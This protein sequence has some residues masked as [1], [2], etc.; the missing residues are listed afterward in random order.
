MG[1]WKAAFFLLATGQGMLLTFA[2]IVKGFS[3]KRPALF[4]GIIL[5]VMSMELL[6]AWGMQVHYHSVPGAF[7]FWIFQSYLLL[8]L[9]LWFLM[10]LTTYDN[11]IFKKKNWLV[12]IPVLIEISVNAFWRFY[13][14][15]YNSNVP[16]LLKNPVWFFLTELLPIIGMVVV[17]SVYIQRL[18]KLHYR[19]SRQQ[20]RLGAKGLFRMYGLLFFLSILTVLWIAGV[21]L[22]LPV[23]AGIELL[24][25]ACL[26]T[27]GYI[28]Y[29][30]I[31][32]FRL[33]QLPGISP[34]KSEFTMY[35]DATEMQR[36]KSAF[37]KD[38]VFTQP[39]L[40]VDQLAT[41]LNL[42]VRYVSHLINNYCEANFSTFVNSYRVQ[43]VISKLA[44]PGQQHKT[45]LALALESGFS[46][47]S[48]F[49]QVFKQHTGKLPSSYL[50][51]ANS[52]NLLK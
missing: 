17:L 5:Y 9:A 7:A 52:D 51:T 6:N 43:E 3:N 50:L 8:P 24:I 48:T 44:D 42:P 36:L 10:Q 2:L 47:K 22:H 35:D 31:D 26:F 37:E 46:S 27:L 40:T 11:Y 34:E 33:P 20:V 49:N 39:K 16:S 45:I 13:W 30:D 4:L 15:N 23:F 38:K 19:F 41:G 18:I 25:T 32:F 29:A 12:F 1:N 28:G 21:V 14:R